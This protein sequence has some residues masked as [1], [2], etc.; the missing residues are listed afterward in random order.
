M[1]CLG[2][3][4]RDMEPSQRVRGWH[5][6]ACG[7]AGPSCAP[8]LHFLHG[9]PDSWATLEPVVSALGERAH[10][11]AMGR[12]GIGGSETLP[13]SAPTGVSASATQAYVAAYSRP[14]ALRTGVGW[15]RAFAEDENDNI[16]KQGHRVATPVLYR[17]G[18]HEYGD[19]QLTWVAYRRP[20]CRTSRPLQKPSAVTSR[21]MSRRRGRQ[22]ARGVR[23]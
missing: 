2:S 8:T 13:A 20:D 15:Y 21:Q 7:E 12:P 17:R 11:F 14:E 3:H 19:V 22:N 18:D 23:G 4:F 6:S 9:R 5:F 1:Q 16:A 10:C